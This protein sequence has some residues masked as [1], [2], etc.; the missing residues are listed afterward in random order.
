MKEQVQ[1]M[2]GQITMPEKAEEKIRAAMAQN[3]GK[4]GN[5]VW[6]TLTTAAAVLALVL[7]ISPQARAA[8]GG[9]VVKYFWPGSDLTVYEETD[10]Q[11][12]HKTLVAVDTEAPA[13]AR[14][15]DSRLYFVGND[16]KLDITDEITEDKPY[17]YT[18]VDDYGLTHYMAVAYAGSIENFG[19]YEFIRDERNGEWITGTGRNFMNP[20]TESRYPWVDIIWAEWDIPWPMPE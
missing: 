11:G 4:T 6:K 10:E 1:N 12:R 14:V 7:V 8:V 19:V 17:Y 20:E 18:Y 2:F 13:F 5:P 15:V 3:K 9:M 16:E